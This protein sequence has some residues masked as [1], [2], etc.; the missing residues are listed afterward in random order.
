[1]KY[2]IPGVILILAS[3]IIIAFPQILVALIAALVFMAGITSLGI[4]NMMKNY[5]R[6][7]RARGEGGLFEVFFRN[8]RW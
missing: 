5:E 4:G 1:M 2:Y 6:E 3:L 8:R 7:L